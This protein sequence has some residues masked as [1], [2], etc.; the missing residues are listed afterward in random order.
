MAH[1]HNVSDQPYTWI[2]MND[3]ETKQLGFVDE[4][5]T[6][7]SVIY[8]ATRWVNGVPR[9]VNRRTFTTAVLT[10]INPDNLLSNGSL[11]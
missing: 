8:T 3:D 4:V 9:S 2:V 1:L 10:I 6:M 7:D 11:S 5:H